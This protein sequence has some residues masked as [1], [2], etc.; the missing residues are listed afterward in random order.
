M[1]KINFAAI[2]EV[3]RVRDN[4]QDNFFIDDMINENIGKSSELIFRNSQ[5][6][7]GIYAVC[8]G[9]GGEALGEEAAFIGVS[10]LKKNRDLLIKGFDTDF[11]KNTNYC[12]NEAN[13]IVCKKIRD[14]GGRRIGTTLAGLCIVNDCFR[15]FNIG[16]SKVF[17]VRRGAL[18]QLT[19]DHTQ[20]QR[21]IKLGI[22]TK[23][24]A[25][26]HPDKNKLTQHIGIFAEEMII[27]P[28]VSEKFHLEA[29]D[30]FLLCSDGL[31]DM[32]SD[33]SIVNIIKEEKNLEAT[34]NKLLDKSLNNGGK[35]NVTIVMVK[36]I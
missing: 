33:D 12:V 9:M 27:E 14:N 18:I 31:T 13:E 28:Y 15:V 11:V 5:N 3:G 2:S 17:L 24:A 7:S 19:E 8:D 10:T 22:I 20:V 1:E 26:K 4:N 29:N 6:C 34:V 23:E 30:V 36:P 16:D 35:D 25:R 32:V 21:L